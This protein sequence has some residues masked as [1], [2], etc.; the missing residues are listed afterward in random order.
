MEQGPWRKSRLQV[1][2]RQARAKIQ[3]LRAAGWS[4]RRIAEAYG[5]TTATLHR[6]ATSESATMP[7]F[8]ADRF[9]R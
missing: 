2:A 3:R 5:L 9:R 8:V 4:Y 1:D 7:Q 6:V